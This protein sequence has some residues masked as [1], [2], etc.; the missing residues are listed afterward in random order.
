MILLDEKQE[1]RNCQKNM[2]NP[3]A[4]VDTLRHYDFS[5]LNLKRLR[6]VKEQVKELN[7]ESVGKC[8][9]AAVGIMR[10]L[11]LSLSYFSQSKQANKITMIVQD[12]AEQHGQVE[13]ELAE[14]RSQVEIL[15]DET[16]VGG[17]TWTNLRASAMKVDYKSQSW[18]IPLNV[19]EKELIEKLREAQSSN[20]I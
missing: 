10:W 14:L 11:T 15:S 2:A 7:V 6:K 4:F 3:K 9:K 18:Y 16:R 19:H 12:L 17:T 8:S 1:W 5:T 13:E 20:K